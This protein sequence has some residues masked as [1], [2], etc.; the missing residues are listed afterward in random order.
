MLSASAMKSSRRNLASCL[1]HSNTAR[2][3]TVE[4]HLASIESAQF[5]AGLEQ[6]RDV[7][8]FPKTV[9]AASLMDNS[10]SNVSPEQLDDLALSIKN[11]K[12]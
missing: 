7:I 2:R 4:Q 1:M 8:A 12:K 5:Y 6:I 9:S 3:L 10:P 11:I